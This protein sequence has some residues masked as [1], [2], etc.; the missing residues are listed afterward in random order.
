MPIIE[1]FDF[2]PLKF[3]DHGALQSQQEFDALSARAG[4]A[5]DVVFIAHGFRN[6]ENDATGLYTRFLGT[7]KAN[8]SRPEFS[9]LANRQFVFAGVY[10]PSKP[11]RETYNEGLSGTRGLQNNSP[12]LADAKAQLEEIQ[13]GRRLAG[14][15]PEPG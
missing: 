7:F 2:F 13:G 10:W 11:F 1:G 12:T 14:A 6:D 3:D 8:L 9:A 4:S 5:T 15:A